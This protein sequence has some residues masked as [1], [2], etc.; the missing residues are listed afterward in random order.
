MKAPLCIITSF[1]VVDTLGEKEGPVLEEERWIPISQGLK[2][3]GL[4]ENACGQWRATGSCFVQGNFHDSDDPKTGCLASSVDS[5]S[6]Y[7][8]EYDISEISDSASR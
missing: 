7:L 4:A 5:Y 6:S 8:V 2:E 1:P 3:R